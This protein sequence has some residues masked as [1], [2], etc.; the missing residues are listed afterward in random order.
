MLIL[1]ELSKMRSEGLGQQQ[2]LQAALAARGL[3][4][5]EVAR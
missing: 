3:A 1:S 2:Q 4:L 5:A